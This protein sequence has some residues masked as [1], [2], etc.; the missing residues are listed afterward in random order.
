MVKTLQ[1]SIRKNT[2]NSISAYQHIVVIV[3]VRTHCT[4]HTDDGTHW[5]TMKHTVK[6][7]LLV[8]NSERSKTLMWRTMCLPT[9]CHTVLPTYYWLVHILGLADA[10]LLL[11]LVVLGAIW[12]LN[13]TPPWFPPWCSLAHFAQLCCLRC[14]VSPPD[15][16]D[17][18]SE[19]VVEIHL[20]VCLLSIV[21][22]TIYL[23]S[24]SSA[25]YRHNHSPSLHTLFISRPKST[26]ANSI[27]WAT[28]LIYDSFSNRLWSYNQSGQVCFNNTNSI[29]GQI[30]T[31]SSSQCQ[32]QSGEGSTAGSLPLHISTDGHGG[33]YYALHGWGGTLCLAG[34]EGTLL[35]PA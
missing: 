8:Q 7:I 17:V 21:S 25:T 14:P 18:Q 2:I 35:C 27:L 5:H 33:A 9:Y 4:T 12:C 20:Q 34:G 13:L 28:S 1:I 31:S 24:S 26:L 6:L 15:C 19:S 23:S 32:A 29:F 3:C 16:D 10:L 11:L 30:S 22:P